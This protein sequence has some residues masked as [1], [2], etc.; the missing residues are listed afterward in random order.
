MSPPLTLLTPTDMSLPCTVHGDSGRE[1]P[2]P[3]SKFLVVFFLF[4]ELNN[5]AFGL[6]SPI[7]IWEEFS[8]RGNILFLQVSSSEGCRLPVSSE[9]VSTYSGG[10]TGSARLFW[11]AAEVC[12]AAQLWVF[13]L[14]TRYLSLGVQR[15]AF[16]GLVCGKRTRHKW[17]HTCGISNRSHHS[18]GSPVQAICS[19]MSASLNFTYHRCIGEFL[20]SPEEE[21]N[22][23]W[24]RRQTHSSHRLLL[25]FWAED[26]KASTLLLSGFRAQFC[27]CLQQ[28]NNILPR[29]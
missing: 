20:V 16:G 15:R 1:V 3:F 10:Y 12:S 5:L 14:G 28:T 13:I 27:L 22:R 4:H 2:W 21:L 9:C 6:W 23:W 24:E 25:K 8:R 19:Q 18:A 29:F 26:A 11:V 7:H 17:E